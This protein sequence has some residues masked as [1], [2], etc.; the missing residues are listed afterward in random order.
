M[1]TTSARSRLGAKAFVALCAATLPA[2]SDPFGIDTTAQAPEMEEEEICAASAEWLPSTPPV[3]LFK[4]LPHPAS[5]CPFYRGAWQNFLIATEPEP[6]TGR[7][8]LQAYPTIDTLFDSEKPHAAERSWLGNIKQAGGRQILID[9]NGHTLYYGIHVNQ[10]FAD[11]VDQNGLRTA[12]GI[13]NADPRL[14][15]PA[16][17]VEFKSAWQQIDDGDPG[18]ADYITTRALVPTLRQQDD[19]RIVE[20]R[21]TPREVMVRLLALHV[22]FTLPGHPEFIWGT[23]EHSAGRPD[24]T[25]ADGKRDVAPVHPGDANPDLSDPNNLNDSTIVSER[26]YLLYR[27]GTPANQANQ[28]IAESELVLDEA[29]Q[30]FPGR[31][32]SIYRMFPGSKANTT[33]A[34]DAITSLNFNVERLFER[35]ESTG[36]IAAGDKRGHYRLVGAVWMDKPAYFTNDAPLQNDRTNPFVAEIGLEQFEQDIRENGSDSDYSILAGEDRLSSTAMESFT[37]GPASFPNCFSCHNTQAVTARGVPF[38]RDREGAVL[39][40]PKLINVSHVLSEFLLQE[41]E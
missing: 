33:H 40:E 21:D 8:A 28:A 25:A 34:D 27:A 6:G 4:P 37:Q 13:R 20:D 36:A 11:F 15:F 38:D 1:K 31:Q 32:T 9:Q 22:V 18:A 10:A 39:V 2:C 26:D 14:F 3:D 29:T 5:E 23:F 19:G 17:I 30:S 12:Q 41:S 35:A 16:G 7:P 24:L